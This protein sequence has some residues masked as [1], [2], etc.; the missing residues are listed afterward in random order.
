[1]KLPERVLFDCVDLCRQQSLSHTWV[2]TVLS[3]YKIPLYK[4]INKFLYIGSLLMP[5]VLSID[6]NLNPILLPAR[7]TYR[8]LKNC[9][10]VKL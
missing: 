5:H 10:S 6:D 3:Q 9:I 1:M 2:G 4:V 7:V 8:L